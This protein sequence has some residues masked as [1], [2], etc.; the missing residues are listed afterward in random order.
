[1]LTKQQVFEAYGNLRLQHAFGEDNAY[2]YVFAGTADDGAQVQVIHSSNMYIWQD[3]IRPE[4]PVT[5]NIAQD[6]HLMRVI[7]NGELV[8]EE[9]QSHEY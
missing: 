6:Y 5:L 4:L 3:Y 2:R 1:M 9:Q 8:Y 7:R